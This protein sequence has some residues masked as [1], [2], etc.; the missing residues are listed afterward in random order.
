VAP[1]A[2]AGASASPGLASFLP[3]VVIFVLF[4]FL[5]IR[6]QTKKAKDHKAMIAAL[7]KGD[8]IVTTGGMLGRVTALDD[9]FVTL[10]VAQNV[11]VRVQRHAVAQVMPK[12]TTK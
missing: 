3:L 9:S 12:G 2:P 5:L 10:A 11:E 7:A 1:A 4:Y 6:P 8:E